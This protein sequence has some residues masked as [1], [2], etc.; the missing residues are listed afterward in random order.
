[1]KS[2]I[3]KMYAINLFKNMMLFS[4]VTVP[5]FLDWA[6]I[7]YTR[8]FLLEASFSLW[9]FVLEIPTGVIADKYGRKYSLALGGL[10]SAASFALFGLVNNY[11][12][13]FL[14]D[15]ICAIGITLLSGADKALFYD[16][17]IAIGKEDNGTIYFSRFETS[18]IIGI[19]FGLIGGS[20]IASLKSLPYPQG[21][22]LTFILSG[23]IL[24]LVVITALTLQEPERKKAGGTFIRQGINGF[25]YIFKNGR[26]RAFSLNYT[27]ISATTFFMFWLYQPLLKSAGIGLLYYGL[28]GAAFNL[29]SIL[30]MNSIVMAEKKIGINRLLFLTALVPGILYGGLFFTSHASFALCAIV[31]IIGLR[32]MRSPLLSDYINQHIPSDNRATVLSGVSMVERIIIMVLYPI[33]GLLADYSLAIAF[34][35]LGASTVLFSFI[36]KIEDDMPV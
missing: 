17:L 4:S 34:L 9:M 6:K 1:M 27:F 7:D 5:F 29:F 21:L 8:I 18:G 11:W 24:L 32:Q 22:P 31:L 33:A 19:I 25:R 13:F 20:S 30:L 26:L 16:T 2:N 28:V 3:Y 15:F 12:V 23:A 10:F 36:V 14:A 35:F